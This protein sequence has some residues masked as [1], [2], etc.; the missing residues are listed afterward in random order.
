MLLAFY[1][2]SPLYSY[3]ELG[4]VL[5]IFHNFIFNIFILR[6]FLAVSACSPSALLFFLLFSPTH[7]LSPHLQFVCIFIVLRLWLSLNIVLHC[8]MQRLLETRGEGWSYA[9]V[10]ENMATVCGL[11][12]L[13]GLAKRVGNTR[14]AVMIYVLQG[15]KRTEGRT[16]Q[17]N[18]TWWKEGGRERK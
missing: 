9:K 12:L 2:I 1:T 7:S 6:K 10:E 16:K 18:S 4:A 3:L 8:R 17:Q 14:V 13:W 15:A 11:Q 5:I